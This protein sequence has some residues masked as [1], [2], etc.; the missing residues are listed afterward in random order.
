[1]AAPTARERSCGSS[2]QPPPA[3]CAPV[4]PLPQGR[5]AELRADTPACLRATTGD[6][7]V[8]SYISAMDMRSV[9]VLALCGVCSA[10]QA[11]TART[12]ALANQVTMMAKSKARPR[13][14]TRPQRRAALCQA[15]DP[16]AH[17]ETHRSTGRADVRCA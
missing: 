7:V 16:A 5:A 9:V 3:L 12:G 17:T 4:Q 14:R 13:S 10:Y 2:G 1:M 11:T 8:N 6:L 15:S